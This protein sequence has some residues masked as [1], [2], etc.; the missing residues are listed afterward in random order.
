MC[1]TF[2]AFMSVPKK[3]HLRQESRIR[4]IVAWA[5]IFLYNDHCESV[6]LQSKRVRLISEVF[7]SSI[8]IIPE[9]ASKLE[10][11]NRY[12]NWAGTDGQ[13]NRKS[14]TALQSSC[15]VSS[16]PFTLCYMV[17]ALA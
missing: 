17:I 4:R 2:R 6:I 11:Q 13:L 9:R 14:P 8:I 10:E 1:E 3:D 5:V 16:N 12:N 15:G 7:Q